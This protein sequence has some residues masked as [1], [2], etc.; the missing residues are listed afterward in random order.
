VPVLHGPH[1]AQ[2]PSLA[3]A[4]FLILLTLLV[5]AGLLGGTRE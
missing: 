2:D 4:V 3:L 5:L 1:G